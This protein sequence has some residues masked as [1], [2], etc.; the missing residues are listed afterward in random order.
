MSADFAYGTVEW[1]TNRLKWLYLNFTSS[2]FRIHLDGYQVVIPPLMSAL[3]GG[4]QI[5]ECGG[6]MPIIELW[7]SMVEMRLD[8]TDTKLPPI[9]LIIGWN[10]TKP[11]NTS[12]ASLSTNPPILYSWSVYV[13]LLYS[14]R[15]IKKNNSF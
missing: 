15:W 7:C 3:H 13:C 10:T 11:L 6:T 9:P 1:E 5:F 4:S 8:W 14:M 12:T 2:E